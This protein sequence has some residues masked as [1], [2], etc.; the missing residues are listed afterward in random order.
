MSKST[1]NS[2]LLLVFSLILS[3]G[4]GLSC[5]GNKKLN[6]GSAG[7]ATENA[8]TANDTVLLKLENAEPGLSIIL[9][10][11]KS[12]SAKA[13]LRTI[14]KASRLDDGRVGALLGRLP[15]LLSKSG[16]KTDFAFRE[17]SLPAPRTGKSVKQP[18]PAETSPVG[19]KASVGALEVTRFA[20]EGKV[21][22][23][24]HLSVSFS[25]PMVAI[26]SHEDSIKNLP[27]VLSP[28]P[29]GKWRWVGTKTLLFDP[30]VRFPMA[31]KYSVEIAKGTKAAGGE[32]LAKTTAFEFTTPAPTV[33]RSHPTHGPQELEPVLFVLFD[34]RI[35]PQAVLASIEV[36]AGGQ[37]RTVRMATD[38]EIKED[39]AVFGMVESEN[40]RDRG[41]RWL[42][43]KPEKPL[44]KDERIVVTVS[45]GAPSAEG[46]L[47]TETPQSF[48]F[49]TYA[50]L[51]V[52]NHRCSWGRECPPGSAFTVRFNNPLDEEAFDGE[53]IAVSPELA[54]LRSHVNQSMMTIRGYTHGRT[55]YTVTLPSM[56]KDRF[57]QTLGSDKE[58]TFR[59]GKAHPR[60]FGNSGL[61]I[62]DPVAK[63]AT[64][65]VH[66]INLRGLAVKIY[67]VT[68]KDWPKF[69]R[70]MRGNPRRPQPAPGKKVVDTTL[71]LHGEADRMIDSS[72]E[73][74]K[75]L[76]ADGKGHA[77][78]VVEPTVWQNRYKPRIVSWVQVTDIGIDS[79][80]DA[81][82]LIVWT[83]NLADGAALDD[84]D[85]SIT[86]TAKRAKSDSKG[87][88]TLPLDSKGAKEGEDQIILA[89]RGGDS[90]FLPE[91]TSWW[92]G[93]SAFQGHAQSDRL[94]W[95][96]FDD[97]GM[98]K[99]G[100]EVRV[101][102]WIRTRQNGEGGDIVGPGSLGV[103]T[104]TLHGPRGNE[105][106]K[107]TAKLTSQGGFDFALS[108]PKTANLGYARIEMRISGAPSGGY[109]SHGF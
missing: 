44:P 55:T 23:V 50:P 24:P 11:G 109:A 77:V 92:R 18:F 48:N 106:G 68:P 88:A 36:V 105:M 76:N 80:S 49:R 90:A 41:R 4:I 39:K 65:D 64:F 12:G 70:F 69:T 26:T 6:D 104:Y 66:S 103:M 42:A 33:Q 54:G 98:Y 51:R 60:L 28:T 27:V 53:S 5:R 9:S 22:L 85:V 8:T 89:R 57:G 2:R 81:S 84:V 61:T 15:A 108:L 86:H 83:T 34:Q 74:G 14:A 72:I 62:A 13:V 29:A 87:L 21:P 78:V 56:L 1:V 91:S 32:V 101:K 45:K 71:K 20:P 17:R 38:E 82:D 73:L 107:G 59:V 16:D 67:K 100:E 25:R 63:T 47:R 35:D 52:A 19:P 95:F 102:G 99:P 3:L 43:F 93:S 96:V 37:K 97:R 79:F 10:D 46:P 40:K 31:T 94:Q 75:A 7:V 30:D 58:L